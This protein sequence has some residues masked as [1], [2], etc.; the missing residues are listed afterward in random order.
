M[1]DFNLNPRAPS[2]KPMASNSESR[3]HTKMAN[4]SLDPRTPSF[5]PMANKSK[6]REQTTMVNRNLNPRVSSVKPMASNNETQANRAAM[7]VTKKTTISVP[8]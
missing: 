4:R 7:Y 1:F 3:E 8:S 2:F 6:S 5:E